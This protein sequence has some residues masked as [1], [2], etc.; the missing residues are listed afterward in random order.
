[1]T[2]PQPAIRAV[3]VGLLVRD[4]LVLAEEYP[5]VPDHHRF[6]RAIGGG[7]EFGETAEAALRREFTEELAVS[8]D[9]VE[10]TTV[11]ENIFSY[12]NRPGHEIV[13]IFAIR[14]S[15]LES[16]RRDERRP[17]LDST[18]SV[19][20]YDLEH[21]SVDDPPLYPPAAL[22]VARQLAAR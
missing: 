7:I 16:I 2:D 11:G 1:M 9:H 15:E 4:G 19:G 17:V 13:H 22:A 5:E 3:A 21:L 20:W 10:L 6:V 8:L 12:R 18:T 14:S